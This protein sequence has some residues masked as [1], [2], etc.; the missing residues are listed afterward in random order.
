MM[1][2]VRGLLAAGAI[3]LA[4]ACGIEILPAPH[5]GARELDLVVATKARD[6]TRVTQLLSTGADPNGMVDFEGSSH[7]AW[8]YSLT[9]MRTRYPETVEIVKLMIKAG[10]KPESAWGGAVRGGIGRPSEKLPIQIVMMNPNV[11]VIR[12]LLDAGMRPQI[13]G[14]ALATAVEDGET[15]I[16]HL[17][18]ER[19][20]DVNTTAGAIPPL[21]AA[22]ETRNFALMTYLE[23][24]GAREKP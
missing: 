17:L 1:P 22:V 19:G 23:E 14:Q 2:T 16:V 18:V 10:A 8:E 12:A 6:V 4:S 7:S 5:G 24:H 20:V 3:V 13:C 21:L 11:E 15:E 9:Q